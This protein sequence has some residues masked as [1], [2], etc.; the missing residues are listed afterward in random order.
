MLEVY[1]IGKKPLGEYFVEVL[2]VTVLLAFLI[3]FG[4]VEPLASSFQ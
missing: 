3:N 2:I 4:R 1:I